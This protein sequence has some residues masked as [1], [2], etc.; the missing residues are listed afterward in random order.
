MRIT[1]PIKLKTFNDK[2]MSYVDEYKIQETINNKEK[3]K[4]NLINFYICPKC[5]YISKDPFCKNCNINLENKQSIENEKLKV[6]KNNDKEIIIEKIN[7]EKIWNN[8]K[9]I[10]SKYKYDLINNKANIVI[11]KYVLN[12]YGKIFLLETE[13]KDCLI[14]KNKYFYEKLK[15]FRNNKKSIS[16]KFN[17]FLS[18]NNIN[19]YQIYANPDKVLF[20]N[21]LIKNNLFKSF[22]KNLYL[23][24]TF[25]FS[26]NLQTLEK[27]L[28][29]K[30]AFFEKLFDGKYNHETI[31]IFKQFQNFYEQIPNDRKIKTIRNNL[32][33]FN[34]NKNITDS[35]FDFYLTS[36][37]NTIYFNRFKAIVK[38]INNID[39]I[40]KILKFYLLLYFQYDKNL[41][42]KLKSMLGVKNV[43]LTNEH[44]YL[45]SK[46]FN[47]FMYM[48][49]NLLGY[50]ET[51]IINNFMQKN[52]RMIFSDIKTLQYELK[53]FSLTRKWKSLFKE[54]FNKYKQFNPNWK[55]ENF[56]DKGEKFLT[57]F[58]KTL[59][60]YGNDPEVMKKYIINF[61]YKNTDKV[62]DKK[63]EGYNFKI[64]KNKYEFVSTGNA[65]S[66]CIGGY[67]NKINK[68]N[69][70]NLVIIGYNKTKEEIA[71]EIEYLADTKNNYID[72]VRKINIIQA[73]QKYN[74]PLT[75][76]QKEIIKKYIN[77][78][79]NNY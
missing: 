68:L 67:F 2:I 6:I 41:L 70:K 15:T 20:Y 35:M 69:H 79:L 23:L 39:N 19:I 33:N 58:L 51:Q 43:Y 32:Y 24:Y 30:K 25:R 46:D 53:E 55:K 18:H 7:I 12:K 37:G 78:I 26:L 13:Y 72:G 40:N 74:N 17:Y 10:K 66:N 76:E 27:I 61:K 42:K 1:L 31:K 59:N 44:L 29:Q 9:L 54:Y 5:Y 21:Y 14:T 62:F 4:I 16:K 8:I 49:K 56:V 63:I 3:P 50:N 77:L 57:Y 48:Y 73:Y 11:R 71:L 64:L 36:Y 45:T 60:E 34:L 47:F 75:E 28:N 52:L 38:Y 22:I 65:M